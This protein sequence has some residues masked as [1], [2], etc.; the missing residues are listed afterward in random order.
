M[1]ICE[2][3]VFTELSTL[4]INFYR[5]IM[6]TNDSV[7]LPT[8]LLK[9]TLRQSVVSSDDS[10]VSVTV[11]SV[12]VSFALL[13]SVLVVAGVVIILAVLKYKRNS[14]QNATNSK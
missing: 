10:S 5:S 14:I 12:A 13:V 9:F 6:L 11:I 3:T 7:E 8:E 2:S 4:R 1:K